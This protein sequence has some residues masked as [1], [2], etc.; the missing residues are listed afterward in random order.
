V[1][2]GSRGKTGAAFMAARSCLR[3]GA[4]MVTIGVPESLSDIFQERVI[5][6]MVLPLADSGNGT[7][8]VKAFSDIIKFL[9]EKA[10]L[11]AIGPGLALSTDITNLLKKLLKTATVPMILDADAIN[12]L[13]GDKNI[14][15][16]VKAPVILTP[17]PGEMARLLTQKSKVRSKKSDEIIRIKI[18]NDKINT[19]ISF[20]KETGVCLVLKG[21]PTIISEPDG[22][23]YINTTGN[24]GMATAGSGDVLT[25]MI[26]GFLAQGL[27]PLAASEKGMHSLIASDIIDKIPSAFFSLKS[28]EL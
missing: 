21:A 15:K 12:S 7:L 3:T 28:N 8:S 13:S 16:N 4:G 19:A 23:V 11:L 25:G 14:F 6:E 27:S 24:P 18:K 17:H 2:A 1:L 20:A 26:S 10:D 5:E 22:K 9:T